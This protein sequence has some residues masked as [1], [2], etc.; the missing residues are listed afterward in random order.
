M[1]SP[2]SFLLAYLGFNDYKTVRNI[3]F[4]HNFIANIAFDNRC[5]AA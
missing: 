1:F 3:V 5:E 4:Q 2:T